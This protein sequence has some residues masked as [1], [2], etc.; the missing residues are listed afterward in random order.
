M[1]NYFQRTIADSSPIWRRTSSPQVVTDSEPPG[2]RWM[3]ADWQSKRLGGEP[4]RV[5]GGIAVPNSATYSLPRF[6]DALV[7]WRQ[8][9]VVF[10][11]QFS[12]PTQGWS[13]QF[14]CDE[15]QVFAVRNNHSGFEVPFTWSLGAA[16]N[17]GVLTASIVTTRVEV[18]VA[19]VFV[20]VRPPIGTT[21]LRLIAD[22][23]DG[24]VGF[25]DD[26]GGLPGSPQ[27][28]GTPSFFV[29][30]SAFNEWTAWNMGFG[31]VSYTIAPL[32]L[33]AFV[34]LWEFEVP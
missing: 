19:G 3:L 22:S 21:R 18:T 6:F 28:P 30:A 32:I 10:E 31:L 29:A 20:P 13:R 1:G 4:V 15:I 23:Y 26:N 9:G 17:E 25:A 7:Q 12:W 5:V 27:N 33:G 24:F 16:M 34:V 11:D 14:V 8:G 2:R